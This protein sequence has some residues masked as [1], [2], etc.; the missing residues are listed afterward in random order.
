MDRKFVPGDLVIHFKHETDSEKNR[1]KYMYIVVS[2]SVMH[3]ET[4]E[5]LVV[6]KSLLTDDYYARPSYMFMSEVDHYQYPDIN[7]KYRFE[8]VKYR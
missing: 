6:Y 5:D 2:T 8:K 3:T 1:L 7:Q 4:E